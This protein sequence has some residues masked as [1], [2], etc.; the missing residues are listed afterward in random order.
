MLE[1]RILPPRPVSPTRFDRFTDMHASEVSA[2]VPIREVAASVAGS[3]Q[4]E[5]FSVTAQGLLETYGPSGE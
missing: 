4:I 3:L 1:K 2:A 5:G